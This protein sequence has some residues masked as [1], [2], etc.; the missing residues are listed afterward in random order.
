MK[1]MQVAAEDGGRP[2]RSGTMVVDVIITDVNDNS[3]R[4]DVD[5]YS[6]EITENVQ[7]QTSVVVVRC[8]GLVV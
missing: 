5:V 6:V 3:P 2:R 4:F 8:A 1:L 7:P